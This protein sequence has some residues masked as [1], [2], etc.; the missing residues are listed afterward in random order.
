[1]KSGNI[2]GW[3]ALNHMLKI[4]GVYDEYCYNEISV[5]FSSNHTFLSNFNS[6]NTSLSRAKSNGTLFKIPEYL[7]ELPS[8]KNITDSND[9]DEEVT[10]DS[11]NKMTDKTNDDSLTT[12][13]QPN[14]D[15]DENEPNVSDDDVNSNLESIRIIKKV[16]LTTT[17]ATLSSSGLIR[18]RRDNENRTKVIIK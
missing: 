14:N 8:F 7:T 11:L 13:I 12:T 18:I 2:L 5:E 16:P 17:A 15:Y 10:E 9:A 1:M 3:S 6:M 4:E